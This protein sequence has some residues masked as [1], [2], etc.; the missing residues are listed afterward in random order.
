MATI[1]IVNDDPMLLDLVTAI[2]EWNGHEIRA[3]A[4]PI[5]AFNGIVA[6]QTNV[7]LLIIDAD[8]RSPHRFQL[9]SGFRRRN[10]TCPVMFISGYSGLREII[11]EVREQC[12]IAEKP[13]TAPQL[14]A[15]VQKVLSACDP[16]REKTL[17]AAFGN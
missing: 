9:V 11:A 1:F 7:D 5:A 2:L 16:R 6:A 8:M 10:I 17:S 4:D 12:V 3:L 15:V 13:F 14:C